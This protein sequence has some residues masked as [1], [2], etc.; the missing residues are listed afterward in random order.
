MRP[1]CFLAAGMRK[2]VYI[3]ESAPRQAGRIVSYSVMVS[4]LCFLVYHMFHNKKTDILQRK[5]VAALLF[6]YIDTVRLKPCMDL[7]KM[8]DQLRAFHQLAEPRNLKR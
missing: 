2:S 4:L 7:G 6:F 1:A 5:P 3:K 8:G